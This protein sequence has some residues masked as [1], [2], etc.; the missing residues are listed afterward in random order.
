MAAGL[1]APRV[2]VDILPITR[3]G[4]LIA[5]QIPLRRMLAPEEIDEA[6]RP[7]DLDPSAVAGKLAAKEAVFKLFHRER[8]VL[9]WLGIVVRTGPG[10]WP[11]V[12]L[13]GRA[14]RLA[15]AAAMGDIAISI[16]HDG[17][18]AIAIATAFT[19]TENE[20]NDR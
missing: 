2:G 7:R 4:A 17:A 16:A 20:E 6:R 19:E 13:S 18:Y 14:E 9:P 1:S 10:G 8:E 12:E 5:A 15:A 3:A 11:R